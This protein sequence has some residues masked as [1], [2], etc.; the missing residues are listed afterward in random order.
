MSG[1]VIGEE[2]VGDITDMDLRATSYQQVGGRAS[3]AR[4]AGGDQNAQLFR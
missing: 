1:A 4:C 2:L 3:N